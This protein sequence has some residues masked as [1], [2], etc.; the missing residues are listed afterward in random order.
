M[1]KVIITSLLG[2]SILGLAAFGWLRYVSRDARKFDEAEVAVRVSGSPAVCGVTLRNEKVRRVVPCE[3]IEEYFREELHLPLGVKYYVV[4]S[5]D[6]HRQ[7]IHTLVSSM[8]ASGYPP[9]GVVAVF[10]SE[11]APINDR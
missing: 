7:E 10:I 3:N 2:V 1:R 9:V 5:G 6:S 8:R 11:P 4:D